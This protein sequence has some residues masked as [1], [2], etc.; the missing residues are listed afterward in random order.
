MLI[1]Y[2]IDIIKPQ[3]PLHKVL[4]HFTSDRFTAQDILSEG[5]NYSDY[6]ENSAIG[7]SLDLVDLRYKYDLYRPFGDFLII[8]C[9]PI[10]LYENYPLKDSVNEHDVLYNL[11]L[12]EYL[13]ENEQ[14]YRLS[15][16]YVYGFIDIKEKE[17]HLNE[18]FG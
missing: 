1:E 15:N 8:L 5:F 3:L 11:G 16:A 4:M 13:P 9:I 10:S 12:C 2:I 6:Y 14:E 18:F 7:I 17:F